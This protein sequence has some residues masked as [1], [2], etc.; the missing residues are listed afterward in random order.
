MTVV[1]II[2]RPRGINESIPTAIGAALIFLV[3]VVPFSDVFQILGII[4]GAAITILSTIIMTIVLESF[5]FFRWCAYKIAYYARG[6]GFKLFW[7]FNLLCF[8][9]TLFFNNDGSILITTPIILHTLHLLQLKPH[10][11]IPFLLSGAII[12]TASSAPIGVSNLANLIALKIVGLD[13]NSY[14]SMVFVPSML[15]VFVIA[16]MLFIYFRNTIPKRIS[17][18]NPASLMHNG[19]IHPLNVPS[20]KEPELDWLGLKMCLLIVL[21]IRISFFALTPFGIPTEWPAIIGAILL[22]IIRWFRNKSGITDV[23]RKTPWDILVFAFSMYV[24]VYGLRNSGLTLWIVEILNEWVSSHHLNGII[25]MGL[26]LT[27]MSNLMNNLPAVM[28]G[29]LS[30]TEM[31]L[32]LPTLQ[33]AYLANVIGSD[34]GALLLPMGTLATLIWMHLIKQDNIPFTWKDYFK[35]TLFVIPLGLLVSLVALYLWTHWLFFP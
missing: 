10:Q 31:N 19:R 6:S 9:M 24:I 7:Y 18:F 20:L 27:L 14:A 4:S 15:G 16:G 1:F 13:L 3:G 22:I 8:S 28:I 17:V 5:N 32:D 25:I 34:I 2:L 23:L 35:V 30:L 26:L 11:K 29:T 12:A 33:V 21:L